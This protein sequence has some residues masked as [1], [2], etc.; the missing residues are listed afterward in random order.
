M[1]LK[2]FEISFRPIALDDVPNLVRWQS[3]P[4]VAIWW[5]EADISEDELTSKW[6]ARAN[7]TGA[8]YEMKTQ[9]FIIVVDGHDIGHIQAYDLWDYPTEDKEIGIPKAAGLDVF[10][11]EPEWRDRGAGTSAVRQFIDEIIFAIPGVETCVI[12]PDP[13]NKRAI[14]SYEKAGFVYAKSFYSQSNK[15]DCYLMR[16]ERGQR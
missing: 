5:G 1:S 11:G 7:G 14:R 10:I 3:E 4:E 15:M 9:R 2:K 6:T 12:D 8:P 13:A 16:Q